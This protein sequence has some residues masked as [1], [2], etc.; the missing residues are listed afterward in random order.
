[1]TFESIKYYFANPT[2]Y[3]FPRSLKYLLKEEKKTVDGVETA[4]KK[5][6]LND[7]LTT[8]K[9]DN[10]Y[11]FA[12]K[13]F[14]EIEKRVYLDLNTFNETDN[15]YTVI[16]KFCV[17]FLAKQGDTYKFT[18]RNGVYCPL[19]LKCESADSSITAYL[20]YDNIDNSADPKVPISL[21]LTTVENRIKEVSLI[22]KYSA[23]STLPARSD[24]TIYAK[25]ANSNEWNKNNVLKLQLYRNNEKSL[26]DFKQS[27]GKDT[28]FFVLPRLNPSENQKKCIKQLQIINNQV[29]ARNASLTDFEFVEESGEIEEII[30]D[31]NDNTK[32]TIIHIDE[33]M[34]KN[35]RNSLTAFRYNSET[36]T[37]CKSGN[38]IGKLVTNYSYNFLNYGQEKD[39][40]EYLKNEYCIS[41]DALKGRIYD[42]NFLF[43]NYKEGDPDNKIE[44]IVNLYKNV[45][46]NFISNTLIE[47]N[48]YV[49]FPNRWLSCPKFNPNYHR[50]N[51]TTQNATKYLY[52]SVTANQMPGTIYTNLTSMAGYNG[53]NDYLPAGTTVKFVIGKDKY[54]YKT[55][56]SHCYEI[57]EIKFPGQNSFNSVPQR[58]WIQ[59][60]DDEKKLCMDIDYDENYSNYV[61]DSGVNIY[62]NNGVPYFISGEYPPE[63]TTRYGGKHTYNDFLNMNMSATGHSWYSYTPRPSMN[64]NT[65]IGLDCSGLV[66]NCI[67]DC[68]EFSVFSITDDDRSNGI[69]VGA[70]KSDIC[71]NI[72]KKNSPYNGLL[73]RSDVIMSVFT[74]GSHIVICDEG[75]VNPN[76]TNTYITQSKINTADVQVIHNYGATVENDE[77]NY[78][79]S[80]TSLTAEFITNGCFMKTLRGPYKH[81]GINLKTGE[82]ISSNI[83]LGRIYLWK[84]D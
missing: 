63:K 56:E 31:P 2:I 27:S 61:G 30:P 78:L 68:N 6:E 1:M 39:F 19:D 69:N 59:L 82:N 8:Y 15:E 67:C 7:I 22:I 55:N 50:G 72:T 79:K 70:F 40:I 80:D 58:L 34:A 75:N 13:Y 26:D 33:I 57:N 77:S 12:G 11:H 64:D 46:V 23:D 54:A 21:S 37:G 14:K 36:D 5:C 25:H 17:G 10:K 28:D 41:D 65:G 44:G 66:T 45:V 62:N 29:F 52:S 9:D 18:N 20:K 84:K 51:F 42:R 24:L 83:T 48:R 76:F 74:S 47:A 35:A 32:N 73:Q 60:S 16:K 49:N 38:K 53:T 81:T 71:R 43:G 4:E 3:L